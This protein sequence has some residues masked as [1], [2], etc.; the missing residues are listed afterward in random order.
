MGTTGIG[1]PSLESMMV[2]DASTLDSLMDGNFSAILTI[3]FPGMLGIICPE[4]TNGLNGSG[5]TIGGCGGR[6]GG[7]R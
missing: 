6:G 7:G 5:T 3:V 1:M 4:T 2:T